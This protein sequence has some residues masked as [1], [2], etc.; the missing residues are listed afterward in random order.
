ME[1]LDEND[2]IVKGELKSKYVDDM[3]M[4]IS[5]QNYCLT[6]YSWTMYQMANC[7]NLMNFQNAQYYNHI[8]NTHQQRLHNQQMN[9]STNNN[10]NNQGNQVLPRR[11]L[12]FLLISPA[13]YLAPQVISQSSLCDLW[14][15]LNLWGITIT[16]F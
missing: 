3:T 11:G 9:A 15:F 16:K 14:L 8:M 1:K 7:Q 13:S 6:Q 10:N 2:S 12:I 4:F 5:W